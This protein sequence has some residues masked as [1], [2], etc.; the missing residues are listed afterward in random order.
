MTGRFPQTVTAPVVDHLTGRVNMFKSI[1]WATDGSESADLALPYAKALVA[2]HDATLEVVHCV[3]FVRGPRAGGLPVHPDEDEL[4]A[5][6][7]R[8]VAELAEEGIDV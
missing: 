7:T 4:K 3:E 2:E 6:I 5:K 1:V 8:Q